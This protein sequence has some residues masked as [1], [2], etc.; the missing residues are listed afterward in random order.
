MPREH[1]E[2]MEYAELQD[3]DNEDGWP[4]DDEEDG[5]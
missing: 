4:Y 2:A 3:A 5:K 1:I